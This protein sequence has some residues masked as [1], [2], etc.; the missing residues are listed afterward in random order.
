MG[1]LLSSSYSGL[2]LRL[3][4]VEDF[5]L[6]EIENDHRMF[7]PFVGLTLAVVWSGIC[8]YRRTWVQIPAA[9]ISGGS[10]PASTSRP[11]RSGDIGT[12]CKRKSCTDEVLPFAPN[13][14]QEA[15]NRGRL[16]RTK[17]LP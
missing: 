11:F 6:A 1:K 9:A 12:L 2:R 13:P 7:F 14:G 16:T 8:L 17:P 3:G 4:S 10:L 5:T 15:I